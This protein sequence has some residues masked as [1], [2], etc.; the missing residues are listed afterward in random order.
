MVIVRKK[1][2]HNQALEHIQDPLLA[3]PMVHFILDLL[4]FDY[5][6]KVVDIIDLRDSDVLDVMGTVFR[7]SGA[8]IV[9]EVARLTDN[10]ENCV[11]SC[12]D[13]EIQPSVIGSQG[14]VPRLVDGDKEFGHV[15]GCPL[16]N[17]AGVRGIEISKDRISW[18][19]LMV[20][21][22]CG[23]PFQ[24]L[25]IGSASPFGFQ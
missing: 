1:A 11:L 24:R 15:A 23:V 21:I 17:S 12:A 22:K 9:I 13:P 4:V 16:S 18:E 19:E 14:L 3:P 8:L 7:D 2:I 6:A 25:W 10:L 20:L 5:L